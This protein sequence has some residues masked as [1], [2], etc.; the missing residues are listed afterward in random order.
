M[1]YLNFLN[2]HNVSAFEDVRD[3]LNNHDIK[4]KDEENLYLVY[5]KREGNNVNSLQYECNGMILEKD[6][7]RIVCNSYNK[8]CK[9]NDDVLPKFKSNFDDIVVE[10]CVE[11]TLLRVYYY[12]GSFRVATKKCISARNS[13]WKSEKNYEEMF[14]EAVQNTHFSKFQFE[15]NKTY[16]FL[17]KHPENVTVFNYQY[18]DLVLLETFR[19]EGNVIYREDIERVTLF[20]EATTY[21]ELVHYM[22]RQNE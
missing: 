12:G 21:E 6:T 7:N 16:F 15:K 13:K 5:Y 14:R 17:L 20:D 8:F 3:L 18:P 11:G 22:N 4:V 2:S 10:H 9:Y 1:E 19:I